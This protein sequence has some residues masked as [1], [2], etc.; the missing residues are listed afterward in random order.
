MRKPS[1]HRLLFLAAFVAVAAGAAF[2]TVSVAAVT[3]S[4]RTLGDPVVFLKGV[5]RQI[6]GNDYA[7]AWQTLAPVQKRLVP[8]R[9]YVRCESA[10]PIPGRLA[11]INV[12]RTYEEPVV[13]AGTGAGPVPARAVTFRLTITEPAL[14]QSVVV[15]H[16]VHAVA[17]G[18]RWAWILPPARFELHRSGTCGARPAGAPS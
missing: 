10:S 7:G 16:T 17:A 11:S 3:Q 9:E 6:A 12:L 1:A 15:T 5:V 8:E 13:V 18:G 14:R 2:A 4:G